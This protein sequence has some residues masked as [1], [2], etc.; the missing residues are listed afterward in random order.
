MNSI[1]L[2]KILNCTLKSGVEILYLK[3]NDSKAGDIVFCSSL[4]PRKKN[5]KKAIYSDGMEEPPYVF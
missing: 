3:P 4:P 5:I 2:K 1:F